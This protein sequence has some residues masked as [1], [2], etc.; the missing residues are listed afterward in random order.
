[1]CGG[2]T[3]RAWSFFVFR[4]HEIR[5]RTLSLWVDRINATGLTSYQ[6]VTSVFGTFKNAT[7]ALNVAIESLFDPY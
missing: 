7:D 6:T 5:Q 2:V 4:V 1:M 3:D